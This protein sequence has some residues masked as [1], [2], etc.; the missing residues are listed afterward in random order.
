MPEAEIAKAV[1]LL[2]LML[3]FFAD[4][5]HWACGCYDDGHCLVGALLHLSRKHRL[6]TAPTAALLQDA[7]PRPGLPLV[8]FNDSRCDSVAEL[9]SVILKARRLAHDHAEQERAATAVKAWLLAQIEKTSGDGGF[10]EDGA[11]RAIRPRTP[12]CLAI[13]RNPAIAMKRSVFGEPTLRV[14]KT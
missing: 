1:Q 2:D 6:P 9:R 13:A 5:S 11:A 14:N 7:M 12:R 10:R 4:D 8:H 3:E